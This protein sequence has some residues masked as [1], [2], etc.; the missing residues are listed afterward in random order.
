LTTFID[1]GKVL[2]ESRQPTKG[3]LMKPI[4]ALF[5]IFTVILL[6]VVSPPITLA[7]EKPPTCNW[8]V[9]FSPHGGAID[10]IVRELNKAKSTILIQ[11]YPFTLTPDVNSGHEAFSH[12][13]ACLA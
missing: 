6:I 8:E 9:Y 10:A 3:N 13:A 4:T 7:Q 1:F 11:A 5:T 2:K 12:A